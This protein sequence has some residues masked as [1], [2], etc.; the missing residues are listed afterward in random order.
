ML[1]L[2]VILVLS[3]QF[4]L[5]KGEEM[6]NDVSTSDFIEKLSE[7]FRNILPVSMLSDDDFIDGLDCSI[8]GPFC[9]DPLSLACPGLSLMLL[10]IPHCH[11][12][13]AF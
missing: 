7:V 11:Q 12:K 10:M 8:S 6:G 2:Y 4:E 1:L 13:S 3:D 5:K 9:M